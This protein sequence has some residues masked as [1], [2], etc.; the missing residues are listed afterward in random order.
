VLDTQSGAV[1]ALIRN[2]GVVF[3]ALAQSESQ[4][5]NLVV[6]SANVF[7]A[8]GSQADALAETFKVFPTFLD[9]SKKTFA[10]LQTFARKTNPLITDLRPSG[11]LLKPTLHDVRGL[12]PDLRRFFVNFDPLI[13]VSKQGLPALRDVL[14]GAKPLLGELSP[15]LEQLNPVLR[16]LEYYQSQTAE[17][18]TNGAGAL[19]DTVATLTDNEVGHYLRQAGPLGAEA[20]AMYPQRLPTNRG[21]AYLSPNF[22][23]TQK[24]LDFL[25]FPNWDCNNTPANAP[26]RNDKGEFPSP[27][28]DTGDNPLPG[29]DM[30][31]PGCFVAPPAAGYPGAK[32]QFGH[33]DADHNT[34]P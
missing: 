28:K 23:Q 17:F 5:H 26:G 19:E 3:G 34:S 2:S 29:T 16:W 4:L 11:R 10:R 8:T 6:N 1:S 22:S 9:E 32:T 30:T 21:N 15:F 33:I 31:G 24:A 18:I 7:S 25:I 14:I 27:G 13:K 20:A 12:S